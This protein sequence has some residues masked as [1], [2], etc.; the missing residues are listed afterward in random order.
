[1]SR[2][3]SG[4]RGPW[5]EPVRETSYE[6]Y[7]RLKRLKQRARQSKAS[8]AN[9]AASQPDTRGR[10]QGQY[11]A[12]SRDRST[13]DSRTWP[14]NTSRSIQ[15][16]LSPE[17]PYEENY[18]RGDVPSRGYRAHAAMPEMYAEEMGEEDWPGARDPS[19][20]SERTT[21]KA[22]P[23]PGYAAP[24]AARTRER[25]LE[26]EEMERRPGRRRAAPATGRQTAPRRRSFGSAVLIGCIGGLIMLGLIAIILIVTFLRSP[27]GGNVLNGITSKAYTQ[28]HTQLLPTSNLTLVQIQNE[29]GNI[30][31]AVSS[32]VQAPTLTTLKK[33]TASS[34]SAANSEFGRINVSVQ[35]PVKSDVTINASIPKQGN[36][37]GDSVDITLTLPRTSGA[38]ITFNLTTIAGNLNVQ[39]VELAAG[40]CLRVNQG[41][42]AFNGTLDTST[43][44]S[45]VPCMNTSDNNPHPWYTFQAEVGNLDVTL[46][47]VTNITLNA[48]TNTGSI[49]G[50]AFGLT[51]PS[52]DNSASYDGPLIGGSPASAAELKLDVGTGNITLHKQ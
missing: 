24:R 16:P 40:S 15:R 23:G 11:P 39:Q 31:V 17:V 5:D 37:S 7:Q 21:M 4:T 35:Q 25:D 33:V 14:Q 38:S 49:N 27:L 22:G 28:S 42:V 34:A 6:A 9:R 8:D 32:S 12:Q 46:P 3:N 18:G 19:A 29:V 44:T 43:G 20:P 26:W 41:N 30:N 10:A 48:A 2:D 1:M 52:S 36:N 13:A 45:L 51:I 47:A 50:T